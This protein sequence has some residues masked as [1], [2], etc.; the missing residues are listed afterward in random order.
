MR[1]QTEKKYKNLAEIQ[2]REE[3][4]KRDQEHKTNR[5]MAQ[6]F[7]R[8]GGLK[9]ILLKIVSHIFLFHRS[10]KTEFFITKWTFQIQ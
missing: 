5:L 8:V 9:T 10:C 4:K 6:I 2:E 3:L 7:K 1:E